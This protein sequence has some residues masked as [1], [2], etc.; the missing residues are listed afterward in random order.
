MAIAKPNFSIKHASTW[1]ALVLGIV[2]LT[3]CGGGGGSDPETG[4]LSV[5]LTDAPVDGAAEVVVVFTGIGAG[6]Q[7]IRHGQ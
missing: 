1:T 2:G 4:A 7:H 6:G 5:N 3:G